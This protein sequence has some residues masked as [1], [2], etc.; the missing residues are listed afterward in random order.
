VCFPVV[1]IGPPRKCSLVAVT[2]FG[3]EGLGDPPR[4][5]GR[6]QAAGSQTAPA[7]APSAGSWTF[8]LMLAD[9]AT[10]VSAMLGAFEISQY[11]SRTEI[12]AQAVP[13]HV[14]FA[15]VALPVWLAA[16]WRSRLYSRPHIA[17]R[18][19]ELRRLADAAVLAVGLSAVAG[20]G[21]K[22]YVARGWILVTGALALAG[23][24]LERGMVR[25]IVA[26]HR[27]R[28]G[29]LQPVLLVGSNL[30]ALALASTLD[31]SPGLGY[32]AVGFATDELPAGS[33][34]LEDLPVLGPVADAV[35]LAR[36]AGASALMIATT[37]IEAQE[38]N[39]LI[40]QAVAA[41]L[42]VELSSSLCDIASTRL[43]VRP[44]GRYPL[45]HVEPVR[46]DGMA[47]KAKRAFDVIGSTVV[48]SVLWP[49]VLVA[50]VL[51][52][53]TSKGPVLFRQE[54]I[55]RNGAPFSVL[56]FRTMVDGA[57]AMYN[58][59]A[60]TNEADGPLFKVRHDPRCTRIGRV[61]RALSIDELPQLWNVVK[62][63]MSLVGPRPALRC[64]VDL[65]TRELHERLRVR[66]GIT[67]MWQVSGSSR[68]ASF[69]EYVRLDLYYVDNWS[70]WSDLAILAKTI[71]TVLLRRG[72]H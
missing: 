16:L 6:E 39:R 24:A 17:G 68:W 44:L 66:P 57:H 46:H 64:E 8:R 25:W 28:G 70:L 52:K 54:R 40:R 51:V 14:Q 56:K 60:S 19:D 18:I 53:A 7:R 35:V 27:S 12:V 59:L 58:T 65:W 5:E 1:R 72:T 69:S 43:V 4:W 41:G 21:L 50:I 11:L 67:G 29:L 62:G 23:L 38:S 3:R 22:L 48:L 55:G 61:L 13:R 45:V 9:A 33:S 10:V 2:E 34:L 42:Q 63:E 47:G 37:A 26:R 15:L 30:E 32:R 71:P 20:F 36:Q 49:V 31:E